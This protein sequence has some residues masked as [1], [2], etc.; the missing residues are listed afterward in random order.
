MLT[1]KDSWN[2]T[3]VA[4]TLAI[5]LAGAGLLVTT[6]A[7]A[8]AP[9]ATGALLAGSLGGTVAAFGLLA[10]RVRRLELENEGL[11]EEISQEFDR[12][13]D[14]LDIYAEALAAPDE[15]GEAVSV[16]GSH[17]VVVK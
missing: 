6:L 5:A 12:V 15:G 17:R 10:S 3:L 2:L 13:K 16:E 7:P 11:V 9:V 4:A 8:A 14:R 1:S